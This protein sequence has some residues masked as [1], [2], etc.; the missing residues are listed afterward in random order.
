VNA[1]A[2]LVR[3]I[4]HLVWADNRVAVAL[5]SI[6]DNVEALRL[7]AHIVAAEAVWVAR[8]M[9]DPAPS[10]WPSLELGE[11]R[12][13]AAR[14]HQQLRTLLNDPLRPLD[15]RIRYVN[16]RGEAFENS[17]DDILHHIVMHGMYHRGQ[18]MLL[19]RAGGG[20]PVATDFIAYVREV[21]GTVP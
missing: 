18:I 11:S 16:T 19:V 6:P 1:T 15:R 21:E 10:A 5:E 9:G 3:L 20:M 14:T 7:Y 8:I 2:T 17:A 13:L 12:G 4:G